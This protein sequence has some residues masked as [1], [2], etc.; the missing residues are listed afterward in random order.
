METRIDSAR[1]KQNDEF[2]I[3]QLNQKPS[4]KIDSYF[5]EHM[6]ISQSHKSFWFMFKTENI[7]H[8]GQ[9]CIGDAE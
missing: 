7:P 9:H 4:N 2:W 5:I 3:Y 6:K 8:S 1:V